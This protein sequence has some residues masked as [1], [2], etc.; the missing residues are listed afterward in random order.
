MPQSPEDWRRAGQEK[1]LMG[2]AFERRPFD[3]PPQE[4]LRA[5]RSKSTG[6]VAE[7]YSS[8]PPGNADDWE[9]IEPP[10]PWDHEHCEF[11]WATFMPAGASNDP[12]TLTEG[13]VT[14]GDRWV[15]DKCFADFRDEFGWTVS[16]DD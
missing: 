14:D 16:E 9:Q 8:S 7:S 11:C 2:A 12:S 4:G 6:H 10:H 3:P 13:Y 1:R 5:W 15:C